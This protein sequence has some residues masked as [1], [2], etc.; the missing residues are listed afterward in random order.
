MP[1]NEIT[2]LEDA[3][4]EIETIKATHVPKEE[5][6][7]LQA[8]NKMLLKKVIDG[9]TETPEKVEEK[10]SLRELVKQ[11]KSMNGNDH[12]NLEI[13]THNLEI[14][15]HYPDK[16]KFGSNPH[17]DKLA[18]E[19]W[20]ELVTEANGDSALFNKLLKDRVGY[21]MSLDNENGQLQ[22]Q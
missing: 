18:T 10:P 21:D 4:T 5:L 8:T 12:T 17:Q 11:T 20:Q 6:E 1:E 9:K 22:Q 16:I 19:F 2:L 15:K 14:K 13:I 3:L 7:R